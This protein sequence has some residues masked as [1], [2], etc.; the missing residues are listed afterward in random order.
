MATEYGYANAVLGI[1]SSAMNGRERGGTAQ[2]WVNGYLL[3]TT[4][5]N[6]LMGI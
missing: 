6:N 5:A 1:G 3:D 2:R 4:R